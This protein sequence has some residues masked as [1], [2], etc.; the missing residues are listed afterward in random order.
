MLF[1]ANSVLSARCSWQHGVGPVGQP[2]LADDPDRLGDDLADTFTPKHAA[3]VAPGCPG[4]T[5]TSWS[6]WSAG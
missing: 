3:S 2:A 1:S 5:V 6:T 4:F